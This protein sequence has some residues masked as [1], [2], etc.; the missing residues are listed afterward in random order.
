MKAHVPF[1]FNPKKYTLRDVITIKTG[2]FSIFG[3][4]LCEHGRGGRGVVKSLSYSCVK[5]AS[6][7]SIKSLPKP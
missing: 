7:F 1:T 4:C 3:V 6:L 2:I 5:F